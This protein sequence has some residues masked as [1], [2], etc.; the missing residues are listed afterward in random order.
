[1][2]DDTGSEP[3][4]GSLGDDILEQLFRD[5]RVNAILA[6]LMIGVLG[7][8]L[9]ESLLDFDRLWIAFVTA[10][11]VVVLIPPVSGRDWRVML[12]WELLGI[13]LLPILVRGLF[14]GELGTFAYYLSIA[15]LALL[16]TVELHM[17]TSLSLT[18]WFAVLFVVMAT[19]A[20]AA[21]WAIV[22][23]NMDLFLGT[24]FLSEPGTSQDAANAALMIEFIYVTLAGF[25]AGVLFD[26]Y[27]RRRD[28]R[29]RRAIRRV[30]RR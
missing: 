26:S 15:A 21:A 14:G 12:P 4:L 22:R 7:A 6:W 27:F 19:L 25:V 18:H 8:V 16:I 3:G 11:A 2:T 10:T 1:M 23:W 9:I 17:F 28:R 13:A 29:L 5:G 24:T 30:V 20:A